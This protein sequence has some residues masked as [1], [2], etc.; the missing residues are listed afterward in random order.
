MN[1]NYDALHKKP[2]TNDNA[3]NILIKFK[4]HIKTIQLLYCRK[5]KIFYFFRNKSFSES[6]VKVEGKQE[7]AFDSFSFHG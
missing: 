3:N 4:V 1:M 6:N 7:K 2:L 5:L